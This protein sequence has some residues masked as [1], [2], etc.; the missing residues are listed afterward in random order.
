MRARGVV[1]VLHALFAQRPRPPASAAGQGQGKGAG[2]A[3]HRGCPS[4]PH[5]AS[6][7]R[8]GRGAG[9][10]RQ[11][12]RW[13]WRGGGGG[14]GFRRPARTQRS[15]L[16]TVL[17][18]KNHLAPS[19]MCV[20]PWSPSSHHQFPPP[21]K[22]PSPPEL[23]VVVGAGRRR[24][25]LQERPRA[26]EL[27]AQALRSG[28]GLRRAG[29]AGRGWSCTLSAAAKQQHQGSARAAGRLVPGCST[30]QAPRPI[31]AP[32]P[33]TRLQAVHRG[34][35]SAGVAG[36]RGAGHPVGV[37]ADQVLIGG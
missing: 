34:V 10:T 33:S 1:W 28:R 2:C 32:P 8:A 30:G 35:D 12:S 13:P 5:P 27:D 11:S 23:V 14:A 19:S 6:R 7:S 18:L 29:G 15:A 26:H 22:K 24:D 25:A 16:A 20:L 3:P 37:G 9:R 4:P 31:L 36:R 17:A 21:A